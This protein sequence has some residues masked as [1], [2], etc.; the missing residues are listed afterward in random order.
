VVVLSRC[1]VDLEQFRRAS[2]ARLATEIDQGV[3]PTGLMPAAKLA[4]EYAVL[5]AR[6]LGDAHI[7]TE[8]LLLGILLAGN[9][10]AMVLRQ[11]GVTIEWARAE[12][13]AASNETVSDSGEAGL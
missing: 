7:G 3:Q 4:I 13:A 5:E 6:R 10:P 9:G 11:S 1:G 2:E 8:H 12:A